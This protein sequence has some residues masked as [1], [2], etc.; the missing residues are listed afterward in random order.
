[1]SGGQARR[2]VKEEQLGPTAGPHDRAADIAPVQSADQ[3][4]PNDPASF[5]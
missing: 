2:L 5:S 4:G 3:S 1:M